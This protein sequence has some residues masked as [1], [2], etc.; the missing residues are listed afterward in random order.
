MMR[1][2]TKEHITFTRLFRTMDE[3]PV[4]ESEVIFSFSGGRATK[5]VFYEDGTIAF[6]EDGARCW[7][8][9]HTIPEPKDIY[10]EKI[11]CSYYCEKVE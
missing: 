4:L 9:G 1:I 5:I 7:V 2:P 3:S 6:I 8:C 11:T 10:R